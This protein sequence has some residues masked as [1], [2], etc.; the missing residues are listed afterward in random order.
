MGMDTIFYKKLFF[1]LFAGT[2]V[3]GCQSYK[4]GIMFQVDQDYEAINEA[5]WEVESNYKIQPNDLLNLKVFSNEGERI[6][7]PDFELLRDLPGGGQMLRRPEVRHLVQSDGTVQFPQIGLIKVEGLTLFEASRLLEAEYNQYYKGC[8]VIL[9]FLN[10]RAVILGAVPGRVVPLENENMSLIEVLALAENLPID[11]KAQNI[12]LIRGSD[13]QVI[14]L[15]T[16]GGYRDSMVKIKPGDII[17]IEP[18]I[19]PG[20]EG[21]R[22]YGPFISIITSAVS[23]I[24][25][26]IAL[27]N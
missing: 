5:A 27:N 13:F 6:I 8:F 2:I 9:E 3:L 18:V 16:I 17:Y 15:S 20:R 4:Q 22:D 7:D 21:I 24:A 26:I 11:M 1:V 19:R 14:D 12:R 10:K 25:V 23:V